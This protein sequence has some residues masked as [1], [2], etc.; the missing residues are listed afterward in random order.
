MIRL[1]VWITIAS[2][3]LFVLFNVERLHAPLNIASFVYVLA[4]G[5]G[6]FIVA[7]PPMRNAAISR[8]AGV[9][10]VLFLVMKAVLGY[11]IVGTNL[12]V[13]ITEAVAIIT[14][15]VICHKIAWSIKQFEDGVVDIAKLQ[16]VGNNLTFD[17][18]ESEMYREVSRAREYDRPLSLVSFA[19]D[20]ESLTPSISELI[21]EIQ[22]QN[23][24]RYL[25]ARIAELLSTEIH[26]SDIVARRNG[27]F[28][29]VLTEADEGRA[30]EVVDR[31]KSRLKNDLGINLAT[32]IASFPQEE[33]TLTGLL[34]RA[35]SRMHDARSAAHSV[36]QPA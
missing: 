17:Q 16:I 3:W 10:L 35:E 21:A 33:L 2:I 26:D 23:Q 29:M 30:G 18:L 4:S 19:P 32:G 28:V 7:F 31:F 12:P 22:R 24:R 15:V 27:H 1:R 14:T 8:L 9:S 6:T 11:P 25:D 5:L 13:T 20:G 36:K 34:S